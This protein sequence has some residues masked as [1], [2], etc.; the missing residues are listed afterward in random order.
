MK[1]KDIIIG[2]DYEIDRGTLTRGTVESVGKKTRRVYTGQRWDF[3]GQESTG[4]V[5]T[6]KWAHGGTSDVTPQQVKRLWSEGD[7]QRQAATER[8][9]RLNATASTLRGLGLTAYARHSGVG[10]VAITLSPSEAESLIV[11]LRGDA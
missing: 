3:G 2:E 4:I 9:Q 7:P 8:A 1:T 5:V 11:R 10:E 6:V